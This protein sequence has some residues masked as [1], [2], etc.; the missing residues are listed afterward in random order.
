MKRKE[1]LELFKLTKNEDL[2]EL[3]VTPP[4]CGGGDDYVFLV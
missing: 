1:L 2:F 3:A 4:S